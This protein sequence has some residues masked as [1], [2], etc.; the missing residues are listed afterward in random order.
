MSLEQRLDQLE[1]LLAEQQI[2]IDTLSAK[3]DQVS[4]E[5][6][7]TLKACEKMEANREAEL[8]KL[9][10]LLLQTETINIGPETFLVRMN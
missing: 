2:R 1:L 9:L 4:M 10:P 7:I 5:L 3:L 8:K 6:N